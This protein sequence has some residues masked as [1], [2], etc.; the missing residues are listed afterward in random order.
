MIGFF[1]KF[2]R[3][4]AEKSS[5]LFD[6]LKKAK[7]FEWTA[8]CNNSFIYLKEGLK[9]CG[10]LYHPDYTKP[11]ILTTDASNK[12]LGF[13]L[14]QESANEIK[15]ILMGGRSLSNAESHYCVTDRDL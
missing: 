7:K 2:I 11:F 13:T 3:D 1:R 12:A 15:P 10:Y 4:F 6:L 5:C 9:S 8:E 14:S